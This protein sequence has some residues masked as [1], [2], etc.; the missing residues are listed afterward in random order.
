MNKK[1]DIETKVE[2]AMQ[3]LD[4]MQSA[5]PGPFFYTRVQARLSRV[6]KNIWEQ[7][8][9][10]VARP[11]VAFSFICLVVVMNGFVVFKQESLVAKT[12]PEPV[13]Y[14]EGVSIASNSFYDYEI[15]E[16]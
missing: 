9:S 14:Y 11:A 10:F 6:E 3:S 4:G 8:S 7:V 1:T 5:S 13:H 12:E 2:Q 16:P 15:T